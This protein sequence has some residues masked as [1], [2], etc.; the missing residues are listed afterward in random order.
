MHKPALGPILL[1]TIAAL[2]GPARAG[3]LVTVDKS[4]QRM[5]VTVDGRQRYAWAVSTGMRGHETPAGAFRPFRMEEDH[6]SREW[7]DAPMPHSIFFTGAGHAIHGS[8]ATRR[9]GSPASHGCVRLAPANASKLFALIRAEGMGNTKV[10]VSGGERAAVARR[11]NAPAR[12]VRYERRPAS[13]P[14]ARMPVRY[15]GAY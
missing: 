15:Y 11:A 13:D 1:V 6:F 14:A 5:T 9:L 4:A 8:N 3:V 10:V 7:D 12:E 2:C